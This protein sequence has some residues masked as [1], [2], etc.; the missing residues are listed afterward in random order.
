MLSAEAPAQTHVSVQMSEDGV[1]W[2]H[3]TA[4]HGVQGVRPYYADL[5]HYGQARFIRWR[6]EY[7][8]AADV[9]VV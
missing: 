1:N 2:F 6:C 5:P 9:T 3:A 8:L 4:L 7:V